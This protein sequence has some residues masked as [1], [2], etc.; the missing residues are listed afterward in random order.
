M[1]S[2]AV[3]AFKGYHGYPCVLCTSVNEQVVHG[4][5][6]GER[7]LVDGDI[8]SID[9]GVVIDGYYGDSAITV[10]VGKKVTPNAKRLLDVTQASL[11]NAIQTV[12]P[13]QPSGISARRCKRLSRLED[14]AWCA[15]L[16]GMASGPGCTKIPRFRTTAS[17]ARDQAARG[18][19]PGHRA[20]GQRRQAGCAGVERWLDGGDT[21]GSLSAHFEHTVAV[22]AEGAMVLTQ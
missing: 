22:T 10:P 6:S 8:V 16:S 18:Y 2:G 1:S 12:R 11:E 3:P 13:G 5:P 9:C 7:V 17:A 14:S 15:T 4:I 19:G 20:N 21:D